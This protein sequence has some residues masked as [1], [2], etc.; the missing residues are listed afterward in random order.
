MDEQ[1]QSGPPTKKEKR[2]GLRFPVVVPGE[3]RWQDAAGTG[4]KVTA[5]AKEVN[6]HG[7]LLEM[8]NSPSWGSQL[9]LTNR[10]PGEPN[11]PRAVSPPRSKEGYPLSL[12]LE[13][14]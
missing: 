8:K 2:R 5:Q 7:G 4:A 10:L 1:I 9:A 12:P 13:F 6:A 14:S 11:R 3:A